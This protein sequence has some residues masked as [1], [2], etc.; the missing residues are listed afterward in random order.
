MRETFE[1]KGAIALPKPQ[2]V[3]EMFAS[4]QA[5]QREIQAS[6][7]EMASMLRGALSGISDMTSSIHDLAQALSE[8]TADGVTDDAEPEVIRS[9]DF[10]A[11]GA[12]RPAWL[13]EVWERVRI[14]GNPDPNAREGVRRIVVATTQLGPRHWDINDVEVPRAIMA[15]PL[16]AAA[17][18]A[19]IALTEQQRYNIIASDSRSMMAMGAAFGPAFRFAQMERDPN[20]FVLIPD[21][22]SMH[23][24][25]NDATVEDIKPRL[26]AAIAERCAKAG[27]PVDLTGI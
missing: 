4:L 1:T 11:D 22:W 24:L 6:Q 2:T 23:V 10:D 15:K 5:D 7:R 25:A 26:L 21:A 27:I 9:E 3:E 8:A 17:A 12:W 13:D 14:H 19:G 20:D 18:K 16:I